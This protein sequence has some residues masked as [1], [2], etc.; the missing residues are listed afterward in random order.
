MIA[1]TG[2]ITVFAENGLQQETFNADKC[3]GNNGICVGWILDHFGNYTTP[4][5]QH[6]VLSVVPLIL[7]FLIAT[8]LAIFAH[9]LRFLQGPLLV[10]VTI[11]F[12]IPSIAAFLI[13]IPL[14]GF[15]TLTAFVALTAYTL[16][17]IFRN[18][19]SGLGGVP[20]STVEAAQGMGLSD[21]QILGGSSCR[22]P[23]RRP[24]RRADRR[25]EHGRHR[26]LR[27]L[28]RR[29]RARALDL[30]E[31]LV[32]RQRRRGRPAHGPPGRR[33]GADRARDPASPH[34]MESAPPDDDRVRVCPSATPSTTSS[35]SANRSPAPCGSAASARSAHLRGDPPRVSFAALAVAMLISI[36]IGLG[37]AP[38]QGEFLAISVSNVGR[39]VPTYA[40]L[41]CFYRLP[42]GRLL[43]RLPRRSS[44]SAIPPILT[45][46]YLGVR[47]V[48]RGLDSA[49]GMGMSD[50][51]IIRGVELPLAI[52]TIW[53]GVRIS[54]VSIVATATIAPYASVNTLGLPI[55]NE[56]IYGDP[57]RLGACIVIALLT[58]GLDGLLSCS[59]GW[60]S[61]VASAS[62]GKGPARPI[63]LPPSVHHRKEPTRQRDPPPQ[64]RRR[65]RRGRHQPV[66]RGLR[67]L[68]L[69]ARRAPVG[70][71]PARR[72]RPP[73]RASTPAT[74]SSPSPVPA[75]RAPSPS[76]RRTSPSSS[77]SAT[78]T[79]TP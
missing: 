63:H 37:R 1:L 73:G 66:R 56:Q 16:V 44:C 39:A 43:E 55:I 21:N 75:A 47:G 2:L 32:P 65:R 11:L 29:R 15:G 34:A 31:L 67:Q 77:S 78:S 62:R 45:N 41:A 54:L 40:V 12:T 69:E 17:L 6:V 18:V 7:G 28:R 74:S 68:R 24:R 30:R 26:R 58:L 35:T 57:G 79:P 14:I 22:S 60:S 36:P 53:T 33:A 72:A 27:V 5:E 4:L 10:L 71:R 51:Q 59:S 38:G 50:W 70:A 13:L 64:D 3:P 42:R 76:A 46:T 25:V 19:I 52:A 48:S 20:Q 8:A 9:R 49:R 23:C 61:R